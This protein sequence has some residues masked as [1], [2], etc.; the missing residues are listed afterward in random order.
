LS[1]CFFAGQITKAREVKVFIVDYDDPTAGGGK[2]GSKAG[3]GGVSS[4]TGTG[5]G[6]RPRPLSA[7]NKNRS[8]WALAKEV[9]YNVR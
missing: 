2:Q 8:M 4:G 1:S 6:P 7:L 3:G 9:D 5:A